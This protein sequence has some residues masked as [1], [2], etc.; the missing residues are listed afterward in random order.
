MMHLPVRLSLAA[1]VTAS[2]AGTSL[3]AQQQTPPATKAAAT[4]GTA[5]IAGVVIDSLNG[6]NLSGPDV[7]IEGAKKPLV[8]DSGGKFIVQSRPPA[9]DR[10][11]GLHPLL[12]SL[13][14][15]LT[16]K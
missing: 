3:L 6:R 4:R 5:A 7:I 11:R 8:T 16:T 15:S 12:A 14:L 10:V 13:R 9:P 2:T 1:V